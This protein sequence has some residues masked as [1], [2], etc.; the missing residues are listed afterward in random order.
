VWAVAAM[1]QQQIQ[2]NLLL[3]LPILA[4]EAGAVMELLHI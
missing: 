1:A 3:A 4:L 2:F